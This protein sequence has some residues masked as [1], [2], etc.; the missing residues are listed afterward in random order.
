MLYDVNGNVIIT[1]GDSGVISTK[2]RPLHTIS[3]RGYNATAPENTI[4]AYVLAKKMG[5]E[6]AECDVAYTSDGVAI[7]LHDST[8]DRTSNGSGAISSM[9]YEEALQYD[10]GSWKSAEYAGTKI[11]TFEEFIRVCKELRLHPYIEIKNDTEYTQEQIKNIID[12]VKAAGMQGNVTYLSF[13]VPYLSH[14]H[15]IDPQARL[16]LCSNDITASIVS[17]IVGLRTEHNE[18]FISARYSNVTNDK[19]TLCMNANLPLTVWTLNNASQIETMNPYITGVVSD[20]LIA[21]KVL[22]AKYITE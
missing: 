22:Y 12:I 16:G 17:S 21:E 3:H 14:V 15:A 19:I 2:Q 11:P 10:F 9:T 4:P 20:S 6:Y 18:V 13:S 7:L 8:I 1:N 5:Y